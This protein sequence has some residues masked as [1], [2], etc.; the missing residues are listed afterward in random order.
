MQIWQAEP[1]SR[2]RAHGGQWEMKVGGGTCAEMADGTR[3][4]GRTWEVSRGGIG[5]E[6]ILEAERQVNSQLIRTDSQL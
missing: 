6:G 4:E 2:T 3:V 1:A 5:D